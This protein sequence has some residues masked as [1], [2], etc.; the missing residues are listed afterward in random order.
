MNVKYKKIIF[1]DIIAIFFE[2]P[3]MEKIVKFRKKVVSK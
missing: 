1:N 3:V 2:I